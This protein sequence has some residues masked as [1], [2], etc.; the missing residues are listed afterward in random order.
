MPFTD[1][2]LR[3]LVG[4]SFMLCSMPDADSSFDYMVGAF[5]VAARFD[6]CSM[7]NAYPSFLNFVGASL[8]ATPFILRPMPNTD[9]SL[10]HII[11]ASILTTCF[12][13][14]QS[15]GR[16]RAVPHTHTSLLGIVVTSLVAAFLFSPS[17]A[18]ANADSSL[19]GPFAAAVMTAGFA[20]RSMPH[21]DTAFDCDVGASIDRAQSTAILFRGA[22]D[23]NF[24]S[25]GGHGIYHKPSKL[26]RSW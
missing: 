15:I 5:I 17:C 9:T 16:H 21:A 2:S 25:F 26:V 20:L 12:M 7:S 4:A 8:M 11:G 18:V 14:P 22:I 23:S 1:S 6:L 19:P 13:H 24:A 3:S 10:Y